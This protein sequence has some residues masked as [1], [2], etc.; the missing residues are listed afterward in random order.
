MLPVSILI[1]LTLRNVPALTPRSSISR[2]P[3]LN[4]NCCN[5]TCHSFRSL[6]F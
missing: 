6:V 4:T 2:V 5:T 1:L 3:P